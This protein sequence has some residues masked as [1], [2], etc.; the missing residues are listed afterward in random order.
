[1]PRAAKELGAAGQVLP[2]GKIGEA[3]TGVIKA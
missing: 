2:L 1:M 3:V